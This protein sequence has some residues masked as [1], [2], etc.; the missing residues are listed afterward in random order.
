MR[1]TSAQNDSHD[2][3]PA[4]RTLISG[5]NCVLLVCS[6][7]LVGSDEPAAAEGSDQFTYD[8][9]TEEQTQKLK[10]IRDA[11]G[12]I[13]NLDSLYEDRT[14]PNGLPYHIYVPDALENGE[15][16]P[17]V[18]FLHG[19]GDLRIDIHNGF[20]KGVWSLPQVQSKH[21]HIL[22]VPRHRT[23]ADRWVRDKYRTMVIEALDDLVE[24][25]NGDGDSPNIDAT[26]IYL[27]GFSQGGM[28]TWNYA[29][30]Y[31]RK[32]AAAAPLSGFEYGPQ[33]V[34]QA[35]A[36]KHLPI[37]IFNG[38]GDDGVDD[39]RRSFQV[40]KQAKARDVRY[41]EYENQGHVIDDFAYFTDGFMEWLFAQ[42]RTLR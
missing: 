36:I 19:R 9:I 16:Y 34:E 38:D 30:Q 18:V 7:M 26:R 22:F 29:R 31:P 3:L 14:H 2:R 23:K 27:T 1:C 21:P 10:A 4:V 17:L 11:H 35:A 39:S 32:F 8:V 37:W 40:L 6:A 20:P 12:A 41:H 33:N 13:R 25:F 15:S 28:G 24:Q 5:F 42:Q